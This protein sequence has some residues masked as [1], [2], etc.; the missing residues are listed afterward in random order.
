MRRKF[1]MNSPLSE[2]SLLH[3]ASELGQGLVAFRLS[4][5][6]RLY[7]TPATLR[8]ER[9]DLEDTGEHFGSTPPKRTER[10]PGRDGLVAW[11]G[12]AGIARL[13]PIAQHTFLAPFVPSTK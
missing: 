3:P 6:F 4:H 7:C 13:L 1:I 10:R 5:F 8:T 9:I 11:R 2:E 12:L